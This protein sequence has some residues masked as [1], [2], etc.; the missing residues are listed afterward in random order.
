MAVK[1]TVVVVRKKGVSAKQCFRDLVVSGSCVQD[2][3]MERSYLV[4]F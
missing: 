2:F 3:R 1:L 4:I